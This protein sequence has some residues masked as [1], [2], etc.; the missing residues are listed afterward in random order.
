MLLIYILVENHNPDHYKAKVIIYSVLSLL[1]SLVSAII[2]PMKLAEGNRAA[3]VGLNKAILEYEH[4]FYVEG[5]VELQVLYDNM[6]KSAIDG[7]QHV[8][9]SRGL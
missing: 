9:R 8:T 5:S 3:F 4:S 6:V 2:K 7:E 1:F